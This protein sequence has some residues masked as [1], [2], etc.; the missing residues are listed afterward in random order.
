MKKIIGIG[1]ALTDILFQVDDNA[2]KMFDLPKGSMQLVDA[3]LSAAIQK[4]FSSIPK[5]MVAGGSASNTI[6]GI[7]RLGGETAFIGK[8]GK[9]EI[10]AFYTA[11]TKKN[12]V[13]PLLLTS[14]TPSGNCTVLVS[15]DGERTMCTYL[16]ASCE[17]SASDLTPD[18]FSDCSIFHIEGYLVQNTDLIRTAA[19]MAKAAGAQVSIDLASYNVV[20]ENLDFL[21]KLVKEHID[22]VFAN[23]EEAKAFT[24]L[25]AREALDTIAELCNI[26]IVKTGKHGSYIKHNGQTIRIASIPAECIDSTGAGDLYAAGFLYG[27]S[28]NYDLEKCGK[29]GSLVAGKTVEIV[30]PKLL[31]STW[32]AIKQQEN[33]L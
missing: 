20:E 16:G 30:G 15:P 24:G 21:K 19:Q 8:V 31:D 25:E 1:N 9:D 29:L 12:G 22:I 28:K 27:L 13:Y 23:E 2:L 7:A 32:N 26:A 4:T 11:D 14:D 3:G 33:A 10:G 18:L 17:L 6:N 5:S